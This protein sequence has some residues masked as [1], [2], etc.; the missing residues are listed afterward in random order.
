[1]IP[2]AQHSPSAG[3]RS[4]ASHTSRRDGFALIVTITLLAFL[5][6][7]LVSFASLTR[8]ETQ[9]AGNTQRLSLARQNALIGLNVALG[10]LQSL[11][12]PDQR[13]TATADLI[14]GRHDDRKRW[15]GVWDADPASSDHGDNIGW[16][17]SGAPAAGSG[18][19]NAAVVAASDEELVELVGNQ[20]VD[21][22]VDGERVRVSTESIRSDSVAGLASTS[23]GHKIG[24]FA[25]WVGDEGVKSKLSLVDP[26][27]ESAANER[28]YSFLAAQRSSGEIVALD[29]DDDSEPLAARYPANADS[30][31]RVFSPR[32]FPF[33]SDIPAHQS[34]LR[35]VAQNRFH[36]LTFSSR[37]I[38]TNVA[39]G[40]L[41]KD[42]TAWLSSSSLATGAPADDAFVIGDVSAADSLADLLP[43]WGLVRSHANLTATGAV[44]MQRQ[45][46]TQVGVY[47]IITYL[48]VAIGVSCEGDDLPLKVHL[49]PEVVLWNPYNV[50]LDVGTVL[51]G[52]RL[53]GNIEFQ[54]SGATKT[55]LNL[56]RA[57]LDVTGS[58]PTDYFRLA[59]DVTEPIPAGHS[60]VFTPSFDERAY[61]PADPVASALTAE[62]PPNRGGSLV[63]E[64]PALTAAERAEDITWAISTLGLGHMG[65]WPE[66]STLADTTDALHVIS[67]I[68]H[69]GAGAPTPEPAPEAILGGR[70]QYRFQAAMSRGAVTHTTARWIA[71]QNLRAPV[72]DRSG[73]ESTAL[74]IVYA[75]VNSGATLPTLMVDG[76]RVAAGLNV[77]RIAGSADRLALHEL[78]PP[79]VPLFSLA[80]LQHANLALAGYYP[81]Y[82]VGNSLPSAAVPLTQSSRKDGGWSRGVHDLSYRL[83]RALW[84]DYFFS[85]APALADLSQTDLDNP[86]Y[87]LPNARHAF[88]R[89][90]QLTPDAVAGPDAFN[91]AAAHLWLDGGFNVNSTSVEAW[92]ALLAARHGLEYDPVNRTAGP[93][94]DYPFSRF[95]VPLSGG[96]QPWE[97][98]R[99]LTEGA[100]DRL[101]RRIVD[102]VKT[103]GP[104]LSLADFVNRRLV[105]GP[106][107]YAGALQAALDAHDEASG[108]PAGDRINLMAPFDLDPVVSTAGTSWDINRMQGGTTSAF[109]RSSRSAFA[110][111]YLTQADI[112]NAIG[113]MLTARSDTFVIRAYGDVRNPVTDEIEGRAWC[114]AVVQ[115]MHAFMNTAD[116]AEDWPV[117]NPENESFGRRYEV[118]SFRWLSPEDI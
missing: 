115:R 39:S 72:L 76:N 22:S 95:T 46:D 8:V 59:L 79:D 107:G 5:V 27:A 20:S 85:T 14:S 113:P 96:N 10:R 103:R 44:N 60:L 13:V 100:I 82:A 94:L 53:T 105:D 77:S 65:L 50:P 75:I 26:H 23:G 32:Q 24:A 41:K 97:G 57:A 73:A 35:T 114:E 58:L 102:Q 37:S 4:A 2:T 29:H 83:N 84:D 88:A 116:A 45:T 81:N 61:D 40:G 1:M 91:T 109:P 28:I 90:P 42:L 108:V 99:T 54:I 17:V 93:A 12:G 19:M 30:L 6:L 9:V 16:L 86:N 69:G 118:V 48:K 43:R 66:G 55:R 18:G 70:L 15:T 89:S 74:P 47:P 80:E 7:I 36:D 68:G 34:D 112:L 33:A 87:H 101:A 62:S 21:T 110:P 56:T 98:Y 51:V 104:F 111:G 67:Q 78:R 25:Y 71:Q 38:P 31:R 52:F 49:F 106:T 3:G 11:S 63:L 117:A 92:K 64:G